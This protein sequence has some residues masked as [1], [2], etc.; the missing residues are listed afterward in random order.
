MVK[1]R[2]R[3][4]SGRARG[5]AARGGRGD[6]D[7]VDEYV[8]DETHDVLIEFYAK[9]C[10]HC[11]AFERDYEQVGAHFA[12]ERRLT[13]RPVKVGRLDVETA[14][15]AAA[16]YNITGLP[17][18][19]LFPRAYKRRG[20]A[21]KGAKKTTQRVIDFV[22]SPEVA[23]ADMKIKDM[24]RWRCFE[25]LRNE[26]VLETHAHVERALSARRYPP[27]RSTRWCTTSSSPRRSART[28]NFGTTPW[29]RS[30]AWRR[31][32]N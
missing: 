29:S 24:E 14:R 13:G 15:D 5:R 1:L 28:E 17:T 12:K 27:R 20:I 10:G 7:G 18:V 4:E 23:M 31:R 11:K 8:R 32:L 30:C 3:A 6:G 16:R 2:P 21:Y 19:Q 22:N 9:W 26:G 25:W